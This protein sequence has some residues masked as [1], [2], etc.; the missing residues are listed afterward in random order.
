ML[1]LG[2]SART[3]RAHASL[4]LLTLPRRL[5]PE[6]E[7]TEL[8]LPPQA[9]LFR[10]ARGC[11]R[12]RLRN[13]NE[14]ARLLPSL[15]L[16]VSGRSE[17]TNVKRLLDLLLDLRLST[18]RRRRRNRQSRRTA[19]VGRRGDRGSSILALDRLDVASVFAVST[20]GLG[21]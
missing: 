5:A 11:P 4:E 19:Q 12:S 9:V 7:G 18:S 6:S 3:L 20:Q 2:V 21:D 17:L 13:V 10:L 15:V 14:L 8:L 1:R 16:L